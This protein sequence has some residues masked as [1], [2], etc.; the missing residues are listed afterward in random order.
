MCWHTGA[1]W[2]FNSPATFGDAFIN[3]KQKDR[4]FS[5]PFF[6]RLLILVTLMDCPELG[7]PA[8]LLWVSSKSK[9]LFPALQPRQVLAVFQSSFRT[10]FCTSRSPLSYTLRQCAVWRILSCF[11]N[12]GCYTMLKE[13]IPC[14]LTLGFYH[15]NP[16]Y[17]LFQLVTKF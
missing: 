1:W 2:I 7:W 15:L 5:L 17:F 9:Q 8:E 6:S 10:S 4:G 3:C 12:T 16:C 11:T 14:L 13:F